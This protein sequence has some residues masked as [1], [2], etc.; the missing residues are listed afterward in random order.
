[1]LKKLVSVVSVAKIILKDKKK[2]I[3]LSIAE[4]GLLLM[5][6]VGYAFLDSFFPEKY[7]ES[8]LSRRLLG[9]DSVPK[10]SWRVSLDRMVERGLV[11]R[12][13]RDG[14]FQYYITSE[15]RVWVDNFQK[16]IAR[17]PR[18]WDGKWR[19]ISFDVPEKMRKHRDALR[20]ALVSSGYQKLH[21]SVWVG[22]DPL[23]HDVF[24]FIHE[25]ELED[26]IHLFLANNFDKE[27]NI[28][29]L[30]D[31]PNAVRLR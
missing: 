19:I 26:Y 25:E 22:K 2:H 13:K 4:A 28:Q 8:R 24:G 1:L 27:E 30:F 10:N 20:S 7:P 23:P 16:E 15:G 3:A 11:Q 31:K 14:K 18:R 5:A 21:N 17:E 6:D 9:L 29:H 12:K